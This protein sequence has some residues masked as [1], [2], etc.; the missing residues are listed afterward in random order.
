VQFL[1]TS[2]ASLPDVGGVFDGTPHACAWRMAHISSFRDLSV[3]RKSMELA[4][5]CY[6]LTKRFPAEDRFA[7]GRQIRKSGISTPSNIAEGFGR[8]YSQ[9]YIRFLRIA[10][11]SDN[12]LQTQLELSHRIRIVSEQQAA[13]LIADAE[14]V[15]RMLHGLIGSLERGSL[16]R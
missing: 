1:R 7:L 3:W 11:G 15:G 12:E 8:H 6:L 14:E 2:D 5:Q 10:K 13:T 9:E 16:E 4:E